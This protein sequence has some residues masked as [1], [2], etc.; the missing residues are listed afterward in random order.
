MNNA[1]RNKLISYKQEPPSATWE[2]IADALDSGVANAFSEKL[3]Q[4]ATKPPEDIWQKIELQLPLQEAPA[5]VIPFYKRYQKPMQFVGAAAAVFIMLFFGNLL[6][7]NKSAPEQ[8]PT[9]EKKM[10]TPSMT[11]QDMSP[12]SPKNFAKPVNTDIALFKKI[13]TGSSFSGKIFHLKSAPVVT[14]NTFTRTVY[15]FPENA[16]R[17]TNTASDGRDEKYMIYID[18]EGNAYKLPKKLYNSLV[19]PT[20]DPNCKDHL[21]ELRQKLSEAAASSDFTGLLDM[22]NNVKE[23]Q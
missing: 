3:Y 1:F 16:T 13:K 22:L 6:T 9:S 15:G 18:E 17:N 20:N 14:A 7:G 10:I 23:N 21:N 19:C 11:I 5:P 2:K 8:L 12:A 4:Y